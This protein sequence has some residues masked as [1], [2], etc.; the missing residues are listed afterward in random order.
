[1]D[2]PNGALGV[3][4]LLYITTQENLE[5]F[6]AQF[7][8]YFGEVPATKVVNS[9]QILSW[10]L[11]TPV[12]LEFDGEGGRK[13]LDAELCLR[14]AD[15]LIEEEISRGTGLYEVTLWTSKAIGHQVAAVKNNSG[16]IKFQSTL[17]NENQ[18]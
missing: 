18:S 12:P 11:D 8:A 16:R 5:A 1:M 6:A 2:H 13:K 17:Y 7:T 10:T 4:S 3:A 15:P 9:I 14:A